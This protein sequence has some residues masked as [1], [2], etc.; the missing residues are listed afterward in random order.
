MRKKIILALMTMSVLAFT[1]GCGSKP[2][3]AVVPTTEPEATVPAS[4]EIPTAV[5]TEVPTNTPEPTKEPT[6]EPTATPTEVPTSIPTLTPTSTPTPEPTATS[7]PVPT[8]T[9]TPEPTATST[10]TPV[11][12][13]TPTPIPT[14]APTATPV[15]TVEPTKAPTATPTVKPTATPKPTP[16]PGD[17]VGV[18]FDGTVTLDCGVEMSV[19]TDYNTAGIYSSDTTIYGWYGDGQ[20]NRDAT[21][22]KDKE[23][24]ALEDALGITASHGTGFLVTNYAIN[25]YWDSVGGSP[26]LALYRDVDNQC[27]YL[28]INYDI[29]TSRRGTEGARDVLRM[30]LSI[31]SSNPIELESGLYED[32]FGEEFVP[33]D[34]WTDLADC[35]VSFPTN[36][37]VSGWLV[38]AIKQK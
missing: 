14:V 15:V 26:D 2:V 23:M 8:N 19:L 35:Q 4:T 32:A 34:A 28:A 38:Y 6:A 1:C 11:P 21:A 3:S 5:P 17:D 9:P 27:Y 29:S 10:P 37:P 24:F 36:K 31:C 13:E 7:T 12:T 22:K 33:Y 30:L 16:I 25:F 18:E 20:D